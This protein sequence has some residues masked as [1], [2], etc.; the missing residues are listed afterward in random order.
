MSRCTAHTTYDD[1]DSSRPL[2]HI[3][4]ASEAS[5]QLVLAADE[6]SDDGRSQFVWLRLPN[7]D[8][9]LGVFPQGDTYLECEE[10]AAY[11]H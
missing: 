11:P 6:Q 1:E 4:P 2:A 8:L 10:D 5:V 3:H 7:G 9:M